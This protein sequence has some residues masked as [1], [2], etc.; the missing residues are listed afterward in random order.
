MIFSFR[1]FLSKKQMNEFYFTTMKSQVDLLL[2]IFWRKLKTPK[3]HFK[4]NWPLAAPKMVSF[5]QLPAVKKGTI[6]GVVRK[7]FGPFY[8][9]MHSMPLLIW[10]SWK[11]YTACISKDCSFKTPN[12]DEYFK[13][14]L[15]SVQIWCNKLKSF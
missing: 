4:I 2:F 14:W 1:H 10:Y 11:T 5:S 3:R 9:V 12:P 8:F 6:F 15:C 13:I 7:L